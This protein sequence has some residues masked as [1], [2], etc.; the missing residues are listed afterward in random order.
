[1]SNQWYP[2]YVG[3][4][5]RHTA[6][7]SDLENLVYRLLLDHY[8][9]DI[10]GPIEV[11]LGR[12]YKVVSAANKEK[13]SAVKYVLDCYFIVQD[14]Y[15]HHI[16]AD[17]EIAHVKDISDK[18]RQSAYAKWRHANASANA[19][20]THMPTHMPTHSERNA[21]GN[22][23]AMLIT[24]KKEEAS[25]RSSIPSDLPPNTAGTEEVLVRFSEPAELSRNT[26]GTELAFEKLSKESEPSHSERGEYEGRTRALQK[27]QR[28]SA[29]KY[30]I[31]FPDNFTLTPKLRAYAEQKG[32]PGDQV[33]REWE[34][35][36]EQHKSN[37][38]RKINWVNTWHTWVLRYPE[39]QHGGNNAR[40]WGKNTLDQ[41]IAR[42][43]RTAGRKKP[44]DQ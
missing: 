33:S 12:I 15:Y 37:G 23:N 25:D 17:R 35:F 30:G 16:R 3:D 18:A 19:L 24:Y 38:T 42:V 9:F 8:Y 20:P 28:R 29:S 39:F 27:R 11:D 41:E 26:G 13:R 1:M 21:E 4:Y 10:G 43:A 22:A 2:F 31:T 44:I 7:L 32:I 36:K 34:K 14:G 40:P 6:G 5:R